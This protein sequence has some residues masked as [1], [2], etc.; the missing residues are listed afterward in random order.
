MKKS[1]NDP[2]ILLDSDVIRH[3]INGNHLLTLTKIFPNRF[4]ILDKVKTELCRSKSLSIQVNNLITMSKV[5]LIPFPSDREIIKEYA[6]LTK[7]FGEGESACM[8]V[9]KYQKQFIASSNL[10]DIK[11]YC[12][13]NGI[14]YIT[15]MDI[16]LEAIEKGVFSENQ[17]NAFIRSVKDNGSML[18]CDTIQQY[19]LIKANQK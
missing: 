13:Q 12:E 17:C 10:K 2:I 6:Q 8:A 11:S 3:F 7:K 19:L 1:S 18:P 9:S 16:L 4:A 14:T 5:P 15:T